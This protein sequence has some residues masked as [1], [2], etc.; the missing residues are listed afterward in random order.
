[1]RDTGG[2]FPPHDGFGGGPSTEGPF[3]ERHRDFLLLTIYVYTRQERLDRASAL[4]E[5]LLVID[6]PTKTTLF[7]V[8]VI[9]FLRGRVRRCR[10]R[11]VALDRID[12]LESFGDVVPTKRERMRS[13]L[14]ARCARQL[15]MPEE[16]ERALARYLMT[17]PRSAEPAPLDGRKKRKSL[18]APSSE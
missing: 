12:P 7:T 13:Y 4:A 18:P 1:M 9:D 6:G 10:E 5:A 3:G 8:A 11:L 15:D 2:I 14:R 16:A 17:A